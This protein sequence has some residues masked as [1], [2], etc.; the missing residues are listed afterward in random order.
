[1]ARNE[2]H[3]NE[4]LTKTDFGILED[5][6]YGNGEIAFTVVATIPS[7]STFHT[8]MF[9]AIWAYNIAL[10]PTRIPNCPSATFLRAK[11]V[12][13]F[14]DAIEATEVYHNP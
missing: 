4:P 10:L 12:C 2:I 5:G 3:G 8:M 1:M 14:E 6:S 11:V 7:V 9:T 13:E